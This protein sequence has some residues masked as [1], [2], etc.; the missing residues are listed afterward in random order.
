MKAAWNGTCSEPRD[1]KRVRVWDPFVRLVHWILVIAFFIAYFTEDDFLTLHVWAGY[2]VGI[3]VVLRV[4]WGFVGPR[5]ARFSDFLYRPARVWRYLFELCA[6][7]AKRFLGHSPAGGAM[8]LTLLVGLA[9]TVWTGL[10]LYAVEQSA[11]PLAGR[12]SQPIALDVLANEENEERREAHQREDERGD[13]ESEQG[14][15]WEETHEM[16]ANLMLA[17]VLLH[18]AGVL[19]ASVVHRENLVHAMVTGYKRQ[20]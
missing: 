6:F 19:L 1:E 9:T 15:F 13:G 16:L 14:E 17:L 3:L 4:V 8:V 20:D 10:E 7:R 5:H 12:I 18:V 2:T 11:G